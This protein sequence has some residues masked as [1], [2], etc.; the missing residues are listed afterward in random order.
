M[1]NQSFQETIA[2]QRAVGTLRD[3][4]TTPI[5]VINPDALAYINGNRLKVGDILRIFATG[6]VKNI[7]TT[8]GL[9]N[10]QVRMG[11]TANISVFDTGNI[12]LNAT[13]H[14]IL[15]FWLEI[16]MTLR[17][18]GN[19]TN[20]NWAGQAMVTGRQFTLTAGQV[21]DAQEMKTILAPTTAPAVGTGYDSTVASILDLWAGFT[22]NNVG[23]GI[24]VHQ[25]RA[26][27]LT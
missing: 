1:S 26:E 21:D 7:V 23:N 24:Q 8:P 13:A 27:L 22:I 25:Y 10:F 19:S 16:E 6:S 5:S 20:A 3:T 15:P 11:P 12:Q 2:V 4:Y 18:V 14:A 9:M 17:A